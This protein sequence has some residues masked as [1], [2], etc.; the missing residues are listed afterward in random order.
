MSIGSPYLYCMFLPITFRLVEVTWDIAC[1]HAF[2]LIVGIVLW[3]AW[4]SWVPW[5]N[6][7]LTLIRSPFQFS[8]VTSFTLAFA[9]SFSF[10]LTFVA[11]I[12]S[13]GVVTPV[14]RDPFGVFVVVILL[15]LFHRRGVAQ[16]MCPIE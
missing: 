10:S 15:L 14:L 6:P 12:I 4:S 16:C 3:H 11:A 13:F 1:G 7:R 8:F 5:F 2:E 9:F